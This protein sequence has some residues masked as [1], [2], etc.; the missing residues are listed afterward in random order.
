MGTARVQV[1]LMHTQT[2]RQGYSWALDNE[3]APIHQTARSMHVGGGKM[4]YR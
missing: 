4:L 2:H 3:G 1:R